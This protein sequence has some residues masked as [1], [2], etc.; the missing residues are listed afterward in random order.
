MELTYELT[1]RTLIDRTIDRTEEELAKLCF[2]REEELAK[3]C[4]ERRDYKIAIFGPMHLALPYRLF[5]L[6]QSTERPQDATVDG[7]LLLMSFLGDDF[8]AMQDLLEGILYDLLAWIRV[9]TRQFWVGYKEC[10][11]P[12]TH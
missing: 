5:S 8:Y 1:I 7:T 12:S 9:L 3:L 4:F 6:P 2:E 11:A 10:G